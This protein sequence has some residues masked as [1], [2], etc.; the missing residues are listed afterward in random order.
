[1]NK[2][3]FDLQRFVDYIYT[4]GESTEPL[5]ISEVG[6][7]KT[8][9]IRTPKKDDDGNTITD[10]EGNI[11]YDSVTYTFT[12]QTYAGSSSPS[13]DISANENGT[14]QLNVTAGRVKW[15]KNSSTGAF[16]DIILLGGYLWNYAYGQYVTLGESGPVALAQSNLSGSEITIHLASYTGYDAVNISAKESINLKIGD[17]YFAYPT[18]NTNTTISL[19]VK[20]GKAYMDVSESN[21]KN[22]DTIRYTDTSITPNTTYTY[23]VTSGTITL[24]AGDD[25]FY[26]S[27]LSEGDVFTSTSGG[28]TTTYTPDETLL[29]VTLP[30]GMTMRYTDEITSATEIPINRLIFDDNYESDYLVYDTIFLAVR[31]GDQILYFPFAYSSTVVKNAVAIHFNHVTF[32]NSLVAVDSMFASAARICYNGAVYALS[33]F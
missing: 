14:P 21:T 27:G 4:V 20:D 33:S 30:D 11:E 18:S 8:F 23:S 7:N 2:F 19:Q 12:L 1:M 26:I 22:G 3:H 15:L 6:D 17:F 32:Y 29:W 25:D 5:T 31:F 28:T 24:V 10:A 9:T 13:V 16:P